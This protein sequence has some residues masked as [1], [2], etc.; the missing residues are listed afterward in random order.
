M[1]VGDAAAWFAAGVAIVAAIIAASNAQSA[2]TQAHA[3]LNQAKEAEKARKAAEEQVRI[4]RQA[5]DVAERAAAAAERSA[6][7]EETAGELTARQIHDA[8]APKF[9]LKRYRG[10]RSR[11]EVKVTMTDGPPLSQVTFRP[12]GRNAGLV[13]GITATRS[14]E[15]LTSELD[16]GPTRKGETRSIFIRTKEI[17]E[18]TTV[19]VDLYCVPAEQGV[20]PWLVHET[21][22]LIPPTRVVSASVAPAR[23]PRTTE[24]RA[25]VV[26]GRGGSV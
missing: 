18:T 7:A 15:T 9:T 21:L 1:E 26:R 20:E 12:Q 14:G 24:S 13:E 22:K 6:R 2:H 3:A 16:L 23:I 11:L 5:V 4:A 17:P 19:A 8:A 25:G 10:T